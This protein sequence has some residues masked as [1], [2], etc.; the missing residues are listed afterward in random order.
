MNPVMIIVIFTNLVVI[1]GSLPRNKMNE[2]LRNPKNTK[3][4]E[5]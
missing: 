4:V 5:G 3:S 1:A 2:M